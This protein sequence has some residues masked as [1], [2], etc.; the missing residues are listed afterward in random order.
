MIHDTPRTARLSGGFWDDLIDENW[1]GARSVMDAWNNATFGPTNQ[2]P[3]PAAPTAKKMTTWTNADLEAADRAAFKEWGKDPYPNP[4]FQTT[5]LGIGLLGAG[6]GIS[7]L[8]IVAALGAG[9]LYLQ[10]ATGGFRR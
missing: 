3:A 6:A 8:L 7:T 2:A 4:N 1:F 10:A 9:Y 5:K